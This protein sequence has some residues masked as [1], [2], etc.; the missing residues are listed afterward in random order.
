MPRNEYG[1]RAPLHQAALGQHDVELV[2]AVEV[3][4]LG[5]QHQ[6][7][8]A[9]GAD[10]RE[11]CSRWSVGEVLAGGE[12]L[13]LVGRPPVGVQPPPGRIDLQEGV[14]DEVALGHAGILPWSDRAG[15]SPHLDPGSRWV[16]WPSMRIALVSPYSWTYP[17]GVTRHIEALAERVPRR[18]GHDVRVLAPFDPPDRLAARL[19]RGA[20]PQERERA[21]LRSS[22]SGAPSASRPTAPSRTSR[23]PRRRSRRCAA[24]C[25]RAATTSS[26]STSRS[27]R[28]SAGTR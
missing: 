22:R 12:E 10:E 1:L 28:S 5:E 6:V 26:T 18:T 25:A 9:A 20:R 24:S 23:S 2:D 11:R 16:G 27:R 4:G 3:L 7:G 17:G 14:L 13:A 15:R 8:V 21:R 19:H